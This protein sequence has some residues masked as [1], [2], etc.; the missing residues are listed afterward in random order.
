MNQRSG[1]EPRCLDSIPSSPLSSIELYDLQYGILIWC[2]IFI[3]SVLSLIWLR[4]GGNIRSNT[5]NIF[6]S[7][8]KLLIF[9]FSLL[10]AP[11][12]H[13]VAHSIIFAAFWHDPLSKWH[14][15]LFP[16]SNSKQQWKQQN[17][18]KKNTNS[19][20]FSLSYLARYIPLAASA[21][22]LSLFVYRMWTTNDF[23][24]FMCFILITCVE[25]V[26]SA[27]LRVFYAFSLV[28][29]LRHA[30]VPSRWLNE[31]LSVVCPKA[32]V[33]LF[34]LSLR[35]RRLLRFVA[36]LWLPKLPLLVSTESSVTASER[37]GCIL[38]IGC[39]FIYRLGTAWASG[40]GFDG[41]RCWH[42]R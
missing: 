7:L 23:S 25:T 1:C 14:R 21:A 32:C 17:F 22:V 18:I 9:L 37:I 19:I 24:F 20:M 36:L 2:H 5:W 3:T 26:V 15:T 30:T 40:G 6:Y 10:V 38:S 31:C 41:A 34:E 29:G 28:V 39:E 27:V 11:S 16:R 13:S 4:R 42:K 8:L 33:S 12:L 35:R